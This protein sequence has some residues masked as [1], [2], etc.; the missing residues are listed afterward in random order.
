MLTTTPGP[1]IAPY[2]NRQVAA[3][4]REAWGPWLDGSVSAGELLG[5]RPAGTLL[6]EKAG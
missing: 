6:V 2:H 5:P 3:L 4:P 1:D